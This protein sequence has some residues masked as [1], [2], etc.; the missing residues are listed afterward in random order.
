MNTKHACSIH[1][2]HSAPVGFPAPSCTQ[3]ALSR[4]KNIKYICDQIDPKVCLQLSLLLSQF[5]FCYSIR[6]Y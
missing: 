5:T 3:I 4:C 6:I 1:S 2:M